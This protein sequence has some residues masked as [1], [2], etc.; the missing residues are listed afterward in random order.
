MVTFAVAGFVA[1]LV[2]SVVAVTASRQIGT[3]EA[4]DNARRVTRLAGEGILQPYLTTA[5]LAGDPEALA[6]LDAVVRQRLRDNGILRTKVWE[7]DGRIAYSDEPRLIGR[8]LPLEEEEL[9]SLRTGEPQAAVTDLSKAENRLDLFNGRVLEVYL[10]ITAPDGQRLLVETYQHLDPVAASG[11]RLWI[12]FAP[13]LI[14]GLLL[15]QLVNLPLAHSMVRRL[16]RG[17]RQREQLLRRAVAVSE[18]ERRVIAE[19]LEDG[20]LHDLLGV[21]AEFDAEARRQE[22]GGE[23]AAGSALR[24]AASGTRDAV[25]AL[26]RL[27]IEIHPPAL[28]RIGL[29][30]A[31]DGLTTVRAHRGLVVTL[32]APADLDDL[33]LSQDVERLLLRGAQ[34]ALA[35]AAKHGAM[36]AR[37]QLTVGDEGVALEVTDDGPGFDPAVLPDRPAQGHYGLLMLQD[38]VVAAGGTLAVRSSPGHGTTVTLGLPSA[39]PARAIVPPVPV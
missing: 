9:E 35:N 38:A 18:Q 33:P 2:I 19:D 21:C 16:Q 30:S 26:Q 15:L 39:E 13:A 11:R 12:A 6:K 7:D 14:G 32:D 27:L 8:R 4:I 1:M 29:G 23:P 25:R 31:L 28:A 20:I 5:V 17:Q 37:V 36:S 22:R 24:G 10:P 3:G 34:E